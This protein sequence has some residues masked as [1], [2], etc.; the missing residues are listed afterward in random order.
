LDYYYY[1][2]NEYDDNQKKINEAKKEALIAEKKFLMFIYYKM[3][4]EEK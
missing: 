4:G 3:Y 1:I 2:K